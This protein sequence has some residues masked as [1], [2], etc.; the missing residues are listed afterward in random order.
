MPFC[1]AFGGTPEEALAH[2][3]AAKRLWLE[4]AAASGTVIPK[5]SYRPLLYRADYRESVGEAAPKRYE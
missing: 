3:E 4:E 5:P 2:L 1:S